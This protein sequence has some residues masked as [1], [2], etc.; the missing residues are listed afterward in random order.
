MADPP[1]RLVGSLADEVR[2]Q[3]DPK[4]QTGHVEHNADAKIERNEQLQSPFFRLPGEIRNMIYQHALTLTF[5]EPWF[6][7]CFKYFWREE[8]HD[9]ITTCKK[10][11]AEALPHL[12]LTICIESDIDGA[13]EEGWV[14]D[15]PNICAH[16]K[17][18]LGSRRSPLSFYAHDLCVVK[19]TDDE[20]G[21][22]N[23]FLIV[24]MDH[25]DQLFDMV[26]QQDGK[27]LRELQYS[28][29]RR[30]WVLTPSPGPAW[31]RLWRRMLSMRC[32]LDY[33]LLDGSPA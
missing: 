2:Q 29:L 24:V 13:V 15:I 20:E 18:T 33:R 7:V 17:T 5:D 25:L 8:V 22:T 23:A 6:Q 1:T 19:T 31:E 21:L 9:I 28:P 12:R 27:G 30:K 4:Q 26:Q 32:D 16:I 10:M 3:L 14:A 11:R